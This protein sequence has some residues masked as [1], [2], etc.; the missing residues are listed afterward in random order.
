[1]LLEK[2]T[3]LCKMNCTSQITKR[4]LFT[5]ARKHFH[6][7]SFH[8]PTLNPRNSSNKYSLPSLIKWKNLKATGLLPEKDNQASLKLYFTANT[9]NIVLCNIVIICMVDSPNSTTIWFKKYKTTA[10]Y[11][12]ATITSCVCWTKEC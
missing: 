4:P 2:N 10:G 9:F 8:H 5:P 11:Y 7:D 12:R 1:M 3:A 6:Q